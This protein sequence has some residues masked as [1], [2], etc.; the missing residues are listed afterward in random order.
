MKIPQHPILSS[1]EIAIHPF[2][3]LCLYLIHV[4]LLV[5]SFYLAMD[6]RSFYFQKFQIG[7]S[8]KEKTIRELG[9]TTHKR[10]RF[11]LFRLCE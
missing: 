4:P 1:F 11:Q 5:I 8:K 2:N 9:P 3:P 10:T 6:F 7:I